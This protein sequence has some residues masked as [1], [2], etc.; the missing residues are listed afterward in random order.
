MQLDYQ[1]LYFTK[2]KLY[3]I[4]GVLLGLTIFFIFRSCS[5]ERVFE[6]TYTIGE[7]TGWKNLHLNGKVRN[8]VAFNN[9]L[10][11]T[12]SEEE[13]FEIHLI[14]SSNLLEELRL[15]KIQG[16]LTSLPPNSLNGKLAFSDPY[17]L[18]GPILITASQP[19][20]QKEKNG[21]KNV[22]GV[23][24]GSPLLSD[25]EQDPSVE[26]RIYDDILEALADLREKRIDGAIFPALIAY[27]YTE[28]FYNQELKVATSPLTDEGIRIATLNDE[29]GQAFI[30]QFN[31][32]LKKLK[33]NGTY[34]KILEEWGFID[35]ERTPHQ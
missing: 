29:K 18:T 24:E 28:A 12:L 19:R 1:S 10:M 7:N 8:L 11:T 6:E 13:D 32:G 2:R 26:I 23:P 17:F 4:L 21:G 16:M 31:E 22:I 15:G 5:L 25:L 14:P 33:E 34:H 27:T 35:V 9:E 30:K 3:I 20:P